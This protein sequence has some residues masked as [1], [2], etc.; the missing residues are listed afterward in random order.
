MEEFKAKRAAEAEAEKA[1]RIA[2]AKRV[3]EQLPK[4]TDS[5][6][7]KVYRKV[8]IGGKTWMAE[9]LNFAAEGSTCYENNAGNCDKYGRLYNWTTALSACPA[10]YHLPSDDEWT[11]L[12]NAVG[13]RS[14]AG[15][16]LKSTVGWNGNG[17][18]TNDFGFLALP[19]GSG[20]SDGSFRGAVDFGFLASNFGSW[21]SAAEI[22]TDL[23]WYRG[24]DY[25]YGE[26]NRNNNFKTNLLSVRCV[27][28]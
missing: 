1:K 25:A 18:G 8:T 26:V 10:G 16:K 28:D 4:F 24:M 9:N 5:R 20:Y 11:E 2:E 7:S 15:T 12:E 6:D 17:N 19:G 27:E 13:G 3:F 21:W 23:A 22:S 14:T